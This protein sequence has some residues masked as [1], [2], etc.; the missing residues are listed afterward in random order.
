MNALTFLA[1]L[2][3]AGLY[4]TIHP[5]DGEIAV[6]SVGQLATHLQ[7]TAAQTIRR[8]ATIHHKI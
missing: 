3:T 2:P 7:M 8:T 6:S 4:L 5:K 1:L